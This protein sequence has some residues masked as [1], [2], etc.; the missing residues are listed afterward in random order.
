[1]AQRD[2]RLWCA[3]PAITPPML[4]QFEV[5]C[6]IITRIGPPCCPIVVVRA[7]AE[8]G[9]VATAGE[10]EYL[11]AKTEFARSLGYCWCNTLSRMVR[12]QC[13]VHGQP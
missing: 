11:A 5:Q 6:G 12:W 4:D 9:A 13:V 10:S 3:A 7:V 1:M 2:A 8:A